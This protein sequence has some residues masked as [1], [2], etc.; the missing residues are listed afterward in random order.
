MFMGVETFTFFLFAYSQ[1]D[2]CFQDTKQ[3]GCGDEDECRNGHDTNE[4]AH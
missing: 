1:T 4:L 2:R 3:N